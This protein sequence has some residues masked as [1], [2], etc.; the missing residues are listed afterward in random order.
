MVEQRANAISS[1]DPLALLQEA[2]AAMERAYVPYSSF[3]VGAALLAQDGRVYYGCNIENASYGA[4]NCA[5]RTALFSAI[6]QGRTVGEFIA[7]AVIGDTDEP[8]TPC[9][10]CRQVISE[11]C[12]PQMTVIL[13]NMKGKHVVMT[14]EALLPG[15]FTANSLQKK[16]N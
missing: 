6:A 16:E 12:S 9:G 4:T 1:V 13:G 15:A 14:A 2:K 7:L 3:R 10:I 8:I 5:E 11:L